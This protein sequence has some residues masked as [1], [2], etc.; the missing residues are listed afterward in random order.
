MR[1]PILTGAIPSVACLGLSSIP[2][3]ALLL[4]LATNYIS[5]RRNQAYQERQKSKKDRNQ[6]L[7]LLTARG[8][9][10]VYFRIEEGPSYL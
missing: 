7:P 8:S 4:A 3:S 2:L 1:Q 6:A 10:G 5:L 9:G